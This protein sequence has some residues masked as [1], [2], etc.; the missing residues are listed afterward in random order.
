MSRFLAS[1]IAHVFGDLGHLSDSRYFVM[2]L[3]GSVALLILWYQI[4]LTLLILANIGHFIAGI[5]IGIWISSLLHSVSTSMYSSE[6]Y[7]ISL[8]SNFALIS[9]L[10][11]SINLTI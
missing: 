7:R 11:A 9:I 3:L 8:V 2:K 4:D 1:L 6:D 10:K 5:D